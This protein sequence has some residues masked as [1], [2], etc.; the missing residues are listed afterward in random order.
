MVENITDEFEV[1]YEEIDDDSD[2]TNRINKIN[3]E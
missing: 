3:E 2:L 1:T